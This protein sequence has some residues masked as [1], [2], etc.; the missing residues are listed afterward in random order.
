MAKA[1]AGMEVNVAADMDAVERKVTVVTR[2]GNSVM[3]VAAA[4]AVGPEAY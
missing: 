4:A 3:E 2:G 1:V